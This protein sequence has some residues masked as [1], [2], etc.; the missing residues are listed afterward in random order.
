[1]ADR[2]ETENPYRRP[3]PEH[4]AWTD[5]FL[6]G[7]KLRAEMADRPER[8]RRGF[9]ECV[10]GPM[11]RSLV[12]LRP[13]YTRIRLPAASDGEYIRTHMD[14]GRWEYRWVQTI[15]GAVEPGPITVGVAHTCTAEP[16]HAGEHDW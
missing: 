2:I 4:T 3:S 8:E 12:A 16:R 15:C 9:V 7:Y 1:M 10:G 14:V 5:G 13:A 6:A 11:D